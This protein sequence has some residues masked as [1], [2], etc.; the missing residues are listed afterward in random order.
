MSRSTPLGRACGLVSVRPSSVVRPSPRAGG[1][2]AWRPLADRVLV[3]L[4][5]RL[6]RVRERGACGWCRLVDVLVGAQCPSVG[7][8]LSWFDEDV[9]GS[10][11]LPLERG[12]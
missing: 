11:F 1:G 5:G 7:A 4:F 6:A 12:A 3:V 2:R 10:M 8:V 9:A